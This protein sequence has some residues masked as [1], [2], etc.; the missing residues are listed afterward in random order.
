MSTAERIFLLASLHSFILFSW[1]FCFD[2]DGFVL[3]EPRS[4]PVAGRH[5]LCKV[6]SKLRSPRKAEPPLLGFVRVE[7][8]NPPGNI[9]ENA[10]N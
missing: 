6:G 4:Q 1:N 7:H 2:L 8:S 10:R 3:D 5:P 9:G